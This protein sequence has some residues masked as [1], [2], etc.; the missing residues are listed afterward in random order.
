M[1]KRIVILLLMVVFLSIFSCNNG[2]TDDNSDPGTD[3]TIEDPNVFAIDISQETDWNYMVVGKDRSSLFTSVDELNDIPTNLFFKPDKD[4]D[5]GI[6][7]LRI[8]G[9]RIK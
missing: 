3:N 6:T 4:S 9:C 8:M 5:D 1:K 7:Y 2:I